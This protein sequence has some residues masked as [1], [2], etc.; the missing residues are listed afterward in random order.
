MLTKEL[1]DTYSSLVDQIIA[2]TKN[3]V[4]RLLEVA[5]YHW[6]CF[7]L[8]LLSNMGLHRET[9]CGR[10]LGLDAAIAAGSLS[11]NLEVLLSKPVINS[12]RRSISIHTMT[13]RS[14]GAAGMRKVIDELEGLKSK[15]DTIVIRPHLKEAFDLCLKIFRPDSLHPATNALTTTAPIHALAP[16]ASSA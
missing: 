13:K 2:S 4:G 14:Y 11:Y 15:A 3:D 16:A 7:R 5:G 1:T 8:R 12:A 9:N 10:L 6:L